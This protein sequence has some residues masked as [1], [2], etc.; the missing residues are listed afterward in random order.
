MCEWIIDG[1][2]P[3]HEEFVVVAIGQET[4]VSYW[5]GELWRFN[6]NPPGRPEIVSAWM[7]LPSLPEG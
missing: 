3:D 2:M 7:E 6:D 1:S 4:W 5:D